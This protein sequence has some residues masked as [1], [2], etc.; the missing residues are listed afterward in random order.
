MTAAERI[1]QPLELPRLTLP[2]RVARSATE[3]FCSTAEGHVTQFEYQAYRELAEQ[4]LGLIITGHTCVSPEGRANPGQDAIYGDEFMEE[5]RQIARIAKRF[6]VPCVLQ[7]GHGGPKA[8]GSNGG[9]PVYSP[10]SMTEGQIREVISAFGEAALRA[11]EC[12]FDGVQIHAAHEYLLSTFLYPQYNHRT[13]AYGGSG[14]RRFRIVREVLAEIKRVCGDKF[15]VF[16]K[17]NGDNVQEPE[18]YFRDLCAAAETCL[19]EG[20]EALEISGYHSCPKG[21][22]EQPLF[23]ETALRLRRETDLPLMLVGGIRTLA[24][25]EQALNGGLQMVSLCRP[26]LR[27]PDFLRRLLAGEPSACVGCNRCGGGFGCA[28]RTA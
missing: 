9:L 18:V 8:R 2:G 20:L 4:P 6:G 3:L 16:M 10:D 26:L 7:V 17:I 24:D 12:G 19:A 23:L 11:R 21:A 5:Q 28:L 27:Q 25:M 1:A 15:P 14:N 13:D 22:P